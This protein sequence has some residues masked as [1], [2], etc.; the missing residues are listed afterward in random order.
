MC[1]FDLR[2]CDNLRVLI[3]WIEIYNF[4]PTVF[5][6]TI[7]RKCMLRVNIGKL[8]LQEHYQERNSCFD[9]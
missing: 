6:L 5:V 3:A 4:T 7:K 8:K 9:L 1:A 2:H